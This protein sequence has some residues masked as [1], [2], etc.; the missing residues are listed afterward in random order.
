MFEFFMVE[1][2]LPPDYVTEHWTDEL[3]QLML[4]KLLERKRRESEAIE[5]ARSRHSPGKE[6][7][8]SD[9]ALFAL[10]GDNVEV[11]KDGDNDR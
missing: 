8:I 11:V 6:Q 1:W 3:L 9:S 5:E 2:R 7:E 10:M 4:D